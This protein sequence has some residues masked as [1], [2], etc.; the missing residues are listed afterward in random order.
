M[1]AI[2]SAQ[3]G[4]SVA[5]HAEPEEDVPGCNPWRILV[6]VA[7]VAFTAWAVTMTVLYATHDNNDN[8]T[9]ETPVNVQWPRLLATDY[10]RSQLPRISV[11]ECLQGAVYN[12]SAGGYVV[13]PSNPEYNNASQDFSLFF[14]SYPIAVVYAESVQTI[15]NALRCANTYQV[16]N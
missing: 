5:Q 14:Q 6:P 16:P 13:F 7:F 12:E 11:K 2:P 4:G 1:H 8:N 3:Q 10:A 9:C 15:Q